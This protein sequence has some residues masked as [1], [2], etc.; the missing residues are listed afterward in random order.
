MR[1]KENDDRHT[2][3][4]ENIKIASQQTEGIFL[5]NMRRTRWHELKMR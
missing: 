5:N 2:F 3:E 4:N 1:W